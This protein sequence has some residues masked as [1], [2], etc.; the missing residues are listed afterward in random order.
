MLFWIGRLWISSGSFVI[1][2][3]ND[4]GNDNGDDNGDGNDNHQ[5]GI[6]YDQ[7]GKN[8]RAMVKFGTG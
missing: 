1:H 8:L 6:I 3:G 4:N 5:A 2:N 7:D